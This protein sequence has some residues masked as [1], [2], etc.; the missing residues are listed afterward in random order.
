MCG[1]HFIHSNRPVSTETMENICNST[2][3]R[4]P[5]NTAYKFITPKI[6]V[7]H[8]RLSVIDLKEEANQ[9]FCIDNRYY[10]TFNGEIYNYKLLR[11][12]LKNEGFPCQT[13]SD[14]EVVLRILISKGVE[15]IAAFIGMYAFVFYD[16]LT[17]TTIATRDTFGV[18]PLYYHFENQ[19]LLIS[20]ETKALTNFGLKKQLNPTALA[21]YLQ[22]KYAPIDTTFYNSIHS[23]SPKHILIYKE[24]KATFLPK[25]TPKPNTTA[26]LK[27]LLKKSV[28]ENCVS[29]AKIGLMLSGGVDSQS[30]LL[31]LKELEMANCICFYVNCDNDIKEEKAI[32]ELTKKLGFQ[33]EVINWNTSFETNLEEY[34]NTIDQPVGDIAG[35]LTYLISKRAKALGVKSLLS[36]IGAD[37][38]F[39]GYNRHKAFYYTR[40]L[41]LRL[42][43]PL[44]FLFKSNRLVSKLFKN[45]HASP[46]QTWLNFI[47]LELPFTKTAVSTTPFSFQDCLQHDLENYLVG[48]VLSVTDQS[49][50]ANGVEVRV[51]FLNEIVKSYSQS[52]PSTYFFKN[53]SK[54]ELRS[55]FNIPKTTK[56]GFGIAFKQDYF[57]IPFIKNTFLLLENPSHEFYKHLSFTET[58]HLLQQHK[59]CKKDYSPECWTLLIGAYWL[60]KHISVA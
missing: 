38:L 34:C 7:G 28:E 17:D 56:K 21:H 37:E 3:H 41:N 33:L 16:C 48:D 58:Q 35:Y 52:K 46:Y 43:K 32:K 45:I 60:Q 36:G 25:Q 57:H 31:L 39:A 22:F 27:Q 4:G 51:P 55:M 18:K 14:T 29:D 44:V 11:E 23:L 40:K 13:N 8:N 54:G 9:P 6:A 47:S 59:A 1:I 15:G 20:S 5:N 53:G 42:P 10:L 30:L 49:S 2:T 26:P 50:M 12:E 19:Q 24:G